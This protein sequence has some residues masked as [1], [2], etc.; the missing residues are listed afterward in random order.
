[1]AGSVKSEGVS[2]MPRFTQAELLAYEAR[3]AA[4]MDIISQS[5]PLPV[6]KE[7]RLHQ[8]ILTECRRR[9]WIAFTGSMAHRTHRSIGEPDITI[10]CDGG[11]VLFVEC[12]S[13]TGKIRP[14]QAALIA[15]A[16][17]LGT[18]VHVVRSFKEFLSLCPTP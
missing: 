15:W 8:D 9:S 14:E 4:K 13:K 11:K 6:V 16:A 10:I 1:M 7:A 3:R 18:T 17:K 5:D 2:I 12:K